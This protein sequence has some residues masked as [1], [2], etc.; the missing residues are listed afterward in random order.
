MAVRDVWQA[1]DVGEHSGSYGAEV[2]AFDVALLVLSS[3]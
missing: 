2:G 1:K 3:A